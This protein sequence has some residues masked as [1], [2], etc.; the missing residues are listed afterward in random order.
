MP[1]T[2]CEQIED[3]FEE[4]NDTL[5]AEKSEYEHDDEEYIAKDP[6]RKHQFDHDHSTTMVHKFPEAGITNNE[7]LTFAPGEGKIP[8]NILKDKNW[9]INSFPHL[10]PTGK[11]KM[12]QEREIN[13]TPQNF[14]GHRL[15]HKDTRFEQCT[16]Y[17]F[18]C[19][20]FLEEKQMER[21]IGVSYSKGKLAGSENKERAYQL[22]DAFGVMDNVKNTPRYHKKNKMEMLAKLD[23]FGLF[24]LFFTLSCGDMRWS[25]NFTAIL[26]ER[27]WRIQWIVHES[28]Q[29]E[30]V[31]MALWVI[32]C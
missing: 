18:A 5:E 7:T 15:K 28:T 11:N 29:G 3:E 4:E 26:K 14:I 17:V 6:I 32:L 1:N 21:N 27:G 19:A 23:N 31:S 2:D 9:D 25:E 12:F 10:F 16:P 8:T 13:L 24:H 20:A 30:T 22:E